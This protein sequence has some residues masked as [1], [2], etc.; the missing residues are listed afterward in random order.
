MWGG[1]Q[2]DL[3]NLCKWL[4]ENSISDSYTF[5]S[6]SNMFLMH[7]GAW[8]EYCNGVLDDVRIYNRALSPSDVLQL[9]ASE[10]P[11]SPPRTARATAEW[12]GAFVVGVDIVDGGAGYTNT[13]NVRFIGGG[14]TGAQASAV[15][16]N[17]VVVVI[18]ILNSGSGYTN[19]PI[20]VIDPPF[21]T[22]PILD[23]ASIS[24][25]NFSNL[26]IGTN[27]QLQQLQPP[28]W[29]N[30]SVSFKAS[31]SRLFT[32]SSRS[33]GVQDGG[34]YRLAVT[35][36]PAQAVA[37]PQVINGFVVAARILTGGSGYVIPPAVTFIGNGNVG[38]NATA[39]ASINKS[40]VVTNIAVISAGMGY[41]NPVTIQIDPPPVTA[42]SP[43]VLPG[44]VIN[45]SGLAPYDNYQIQFKADMGAAWGNL[46]GG[47]FYPTNEQNAQYIFLTNNTGYFQLEYLP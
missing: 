46:S 38:S 30:Q 45:S 33:P 4:L 47:L 23:I 29:I 13:P 34:N 32:R 2:W 35:P 42:L 26:N 11:P 25:L 22:N 6:E 10:A 14:G 15:V 7:S 9:Y 16:N 37:A 5:G 18:I 31:K 28:N 20:V 21:I 39:V 19:T 8:N 36:T 3:S 1:I 44:V 12:A 43:T 17:G 40:G 27:Y 24:M 41:V